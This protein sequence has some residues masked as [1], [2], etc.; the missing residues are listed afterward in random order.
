MA[1]AATIFT[2]SCGED[3]SNGKDGADC[4]IT[5]AFA[6]V[7]GGQVVGEL[8]SGASGASGTDG[9]PGAQGKSCTVNKSSGGWQVLCGGELKGTLDG[10]DVTQNATNI[11]ET[12]I[13]C[14]AT[15]VIL[16]SS[17][18]LL[19]GNICPIDGTEQY[20]EGICGP[21]KTV[22][23]GSRKYCGFATKGSVA[24]GTPTVLD[25]CDPDPA[26]DQPNEA[27]MYITERDTAWV[28]LAAIGGSFT[29][30]EENNVW[31]DQYCAVT[32]TAPVLG[33]YPAGTDPYATDQLKTMETKTT[34]TPEQCGNG[35]ALSK[36]NENSW[37]GEYCGYKSAASYAAFTKEKLSNG[38]SDGTK[39]DEASYTGKYCAM[40]KKEH[41]YSQLSDGFCGTYSVHIDNSNSSNPN[42]LVKVYTGT[43]FPLNKIPDGKHTLLT[44]ADF[45]NEY[46]G[47]TAANYFLTRKSIMDIGDPTG[48]Q[49]DFVYATVVK[50]AKKV[51]EDGSFLDLASIYDND[52]KGYLVDEKGANSGVKFP[53][54]KNQY[55]QV[56]AFGGKSEVVGGADAY[57]MKSKEEFLTLT[58]GSTQT[59]GGTNAA[60]GDSV[61]MQVFSRG[62]TAHRLNED[63]WKGEYC[64][65]KT[66]TDFY[67]GATNGTST[68]NF[69]TS[70]ATT[71]ANFDPSSVTTSFT[72]LPSNRT[73]TK[74][75]SCHG[76]KGALVTDA[77]AEYNAP[78]SVSK[79]DAQTKKYWP[80]EYCQWQDTKG[81]T[82][83]VVSIPEFTNYSTSDDAD[84]T[85]ITGETATV[86]DNYCFSLIPTISFAEGQDRNKETLKRLMGVYGTSGAS[87][88]NFLK[89]L[90]DGSWQ[91]QYCGFK[92]QTDYTNLTRTVLTTICKTP[93][94]VRTSGKQP[95]DYSLTK[96]N[97]S[98]TAFPREY[99]QYSKNVNTGVISA[100]VVG[101]YSIDGSGVPTERT[102]VYDL[103]KYFCYQPSKSAKKEIDALGGTG[104]AA[105]YNTKSSNAPT[106]NDGSWKSEYCAYTS[107]TSINDEI[108]FKKSVGCENGEMPNAA[109]SATAWQNEYCGMKRHSA[110][111]S[112]LLGGSEAYC[113]VNTDANPN[114]WLTATADNFRLNAGTT[115]KGEY[116]FVDDKKGICLGGQ[117]PIPGAKSDDSPKCYEPD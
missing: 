25:I 86:L 92:N 43:K 89:K 72:A 48:N 24:A 80:N 114:A 113:G 16:C 54:W 82:I 64:G 111:E 51:C 76:S 102:S 45:S 109:L 44:P 78:N 11:Y 34:A 21:N 98:A 107:G 30:S 40:L 46:C 75:V 66:V 52:I 69:P 18:M 10:C 22:Y 65:Y 33:T 8:E 41:K 4:T 28:L 37:K 29:F 94:G 23:D 110:F 3:G 50:D 55:C 112:S 62:S 73:P 60:R 47:L 19:E 108:N 12:T 96:N 106:L 9:Q 77:G 90:N 99:C 26:S 14:G 71:A 95:N 79:V 117:V 81:T 91:N 103:N 83:K 101:L 58:T 74:M 104:V 27:F 53:T 93:E 1:M 97:N 56:K 38:C 42:K 2:I 36:F 13:S 35:T 20:P 84:K 57:C 67:I 5:S 59:I 70:G 15:N 87:G 7:C 32:R 31:E 39:P 49:D 105:F 116:C 68:A 6:V 88:Q 115:W 61:N 17:K 63:S 85:A 100:E